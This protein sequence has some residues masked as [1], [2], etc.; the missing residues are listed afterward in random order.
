MPGVS[1]I[2]G[3][4]HHHSGQVSHFNN[5]SGGPR[6]ETFFTMVSNLEFLNPVSKM[7]QSRHRPVFAN[8]S[9]TNFGAVR[10][11]AFCCGLLVASE[12]RA[13]EAGGLASSIHP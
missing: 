1:S 4:Y 13:V 5:F 7:S 3:Q 11:V 9:A 8:L 10:A 6:N 12:I 2:R